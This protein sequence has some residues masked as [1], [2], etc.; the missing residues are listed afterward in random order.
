MTFLITLPKGDT[1]D[2]ACNPGYDEAATTDEPNVGLAIA[3]A[4]GAI[5]ESTPKEPVIECPGGLSNAPSEFFIKQT[6]KSFCEDVMGNL[7]SSHGP[8]AY[9]IKGD[10]IPILKNKLLQ[11]TKRSP[12]ENIDNYGDYRFFLSYEKKDGECLVDKEDLCRNAY[13]NLVHSNCEFPIYTP[14]PPGSVQVS[15]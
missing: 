6:S 1:K 9:S 5:E 12:P 11:V 14:S 10:K 4:L 13:E 8:T 7:D 3:E 2:C 15:W